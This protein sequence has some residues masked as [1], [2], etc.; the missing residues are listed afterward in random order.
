MRKTAISSNIKNLVAYD[1]FGDSFWIFL[2]L[3]HVLSEQVSETKSPVQNGKEIPEPSSNERWEETSHQVKGFTSKLRQMI[4]D[5]V[6]NISV[7]NTS[8]T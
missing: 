1:G 7:E 6:N 4:Q 5:R 2:A 3:F 8:N